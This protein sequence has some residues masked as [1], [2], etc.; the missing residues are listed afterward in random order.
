MRSA[1]KLIA[2]IAAVFYLGVGV[3]AFAARLSFFTDIGPYPPYNEHF[4]HD[5]G[6]FN[7]GLG[8][9]GDCS[10]P[11][12]RGPPRLFLDLEQR[13]RPFHVADPIGS[14]PDSGQLSRARWGGRR[15]S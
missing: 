14:A 9:P 13:Y 12:V 11:G 5:V 3:W 6:A 4:I 7:L 10:D 1:A 15:R 8:D 2:G